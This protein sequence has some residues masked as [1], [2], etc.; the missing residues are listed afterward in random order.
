MDIHILVRASF[1]IMIFLGSFYL[2]AMPGHFP[3]NIR[4]VGVVSI[5]ATDALES[6]HQWMNKTLVNNTNSIPGERMLQIMTCKSTEEVAVASDMCLQQDLQ[7]Q[8]LKRVHSAEVRVAAAQRRALQRQQE[9]LSVLPAQAMPIPDRPD[10]QV[11]LNKL[12]R[13]YRA[14]ERESRRSSKHQKTDNTMS[15][16]AASSSS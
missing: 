14:K 12:K 1:M 16:S 10:L 5:Y 13:E 7:R 2:H 9:I 11:Q 15:V 8:E 6:G 4:S 3:N